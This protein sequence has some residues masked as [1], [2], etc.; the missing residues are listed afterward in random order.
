MIAEHLSIDGSVVS[1]E[2]E[3]DLSTAV[4]ATGWAIVPSIARAHPFRISPPGY[5]RIVE[6]AVRKSFSDIRIGKMQEF[7]LRGGN[8]HVAEVEMPVATGGTRKL[9]VGGW[10]GKMGCLST[11]VRD[12]STDR[13]VEMFDSLQFSEG[14]MGLRIDSPVTPRPRE[15]R[16]VKE[17]PGLGILS[18]RPAIAS[19]LEMIPRSAGAA[20]RHGELFRVAADRSDLIHVSRTAVTWIRTVDEDGSNER[21]TAAAVD[22]H[23]EWSP[24]RASR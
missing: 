13:L 5:V 9:T 7:S 17:V 4:T 12:A 21:R 6:Q 3:A 15:P 1:I 2:S 10:E 24:R 20:A 16:V 14:S 18:I 23:V 11:S 19:V 8:L 22:L